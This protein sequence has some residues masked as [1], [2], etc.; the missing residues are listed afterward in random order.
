MNEFMNPE[1]DVLGNLISTIHNLE[2]AL[3][4][5]DGVCCGM[6]CDCYQNNKSDLKEAYAEL[7]KFN[8]C[9]VDG[10]LCEFTYIDGKMVVE[11]YDIP[12]SVDNAMEA[13]YP[14][15]F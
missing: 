13:Y 15:A 12:A 3:E 4:N 14:D 6:A 1:I 8:Y 7:A 9:Y 10:E 11:K 5:Y 2:W